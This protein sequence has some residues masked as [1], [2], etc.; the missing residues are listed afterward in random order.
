[1]LS[2]RVARLMA[3]YLA[4]FRFSWWRP[5]WPTNIDEI[6]S[7]HLRM[8]HELCA[9]PPPS[10]KITL[11]RRK[12]QAQKALLVNHKIRPGFALKPNRL[13]TATRPGGAGL[14]IAVFRGHLRS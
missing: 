5:F 9:T 7:L 6:R 11:S 12:N 14:W 10:E 8:N 4:L 3:T 13:T 2:H 1:M